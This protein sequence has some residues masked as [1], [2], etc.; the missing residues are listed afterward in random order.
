MY[1]EIINSRQA[2]VLLSG[3]IVGSTAILGV[4]TDTKQDVWITILLA[5]ILAS[6]IY[7]VYA[8][9]IALVPG[10]NLFEIL[11]FLFGKIVGRMVSVVFI[12]YA[13]YLQALVT[14]SFTEF[15]R[16]IS[17]QETPLFIIAL[18]A[19]LLSA[20]AIRD[21]LE[22]FARW[23]S[24]FFPIVV[25][26]ILIITFLTIP[27]IGFENLSP[28]LYNGIGPIINS[29]TSAFSFP[30]AEAVLFIAILN[31]LRRNES[32]YKVFFW[33][34]LI[35]GLLILIIATRT[36][37]VLGPENTSLQHYGSY[38]S[39][40][41]IN[42]GNFLQRIEVSVSIVFIVTGFIKGSVCLYASSKGI[43]HL[44]F[45]KMDYKKLAPPINLLN[46][47]FS[48]IVFKNAIQMFEWAE[49]LY[50]Y[51]AFPF[52]VV[53]PIIMLIVA[54]VKTREAKNDN[55]SIQAD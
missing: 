55:Q 31:S 16:A 5:M 50:K 10:K 6:I 45:N 52:Q 27:W 34:L 32:P 35:G 1:K 44:L 46:A 43:S 4:G 11:D 25:I 14:R 22:V 19:S 15:I 48:L 13:F 30:F 36:V 21:G 33:S 29:A 12:W 3:F 28:T 40:R 53:I 42:L 49:H 26:F 2:I 54:E 24:I 18:S 51:F 20:W 47:L 23:A 38:A 17:L 8:R 41:L 37:L 7:F 9:I 39:V